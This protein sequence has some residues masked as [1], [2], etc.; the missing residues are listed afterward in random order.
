MLARRV[1][2]FACSVAHRLSSASSPERPPWPRR[3]RTRRSDGW[4]HWSGL[5]LSRIIRRAARVTGARPEVRTDEG[6]ARRDG[7]SDSRRAG[8]RLRMC[9]LAGCKATDVPGH[10][11]RRRRLLP[12][13]VDNSPAL[14]LVTFGAGIVAN[15]TDRFAVARALHQLVRERAEAV[16]NWRLQAGALTQL[17][18]SVLRHERDIEKARSSHTL[19]LHFVG[20][21]AMT[22]EWPTASKAWRET[23]SLMATTRRRSTYFTKQWHTVA[24]LE[25]RLESRVIS[26]APQ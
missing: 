21:K 23:P 1:G 8:Q 13:A 20:S 7:H 17:A 4:N 6:V 3:V 11:V 26:V 25:T 9:A 5:R 18:G 22:G 19:A 14:L 15:H 12:H 10:L 24:Q 2:Q 16:G